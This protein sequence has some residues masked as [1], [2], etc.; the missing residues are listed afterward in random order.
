MAKLFSIPTQLIA[1]R[2]MCSRDPK[3]SGALLS[4]L[5]ASH[6]HGAE[7]TEALKAVLKYVRLKGSPP[8]FQVLAE[9]LKLSPET[10]DFLAEATTSP[11]TYDHAQQVIERLN[12]Y[13][14]TRI[15]FSLCKEGME[16]LQGKT[17]DPEEL[18]AMAQEKLSAMQLNKDVENQL[19]HIGRDGNSDEL[20]TKAIY[21]ADDDQWIPTCWKT[22]DSVNGGMPRGGLVLLGGST[23]AGKSHCVLQ[24]AKSQASLGYKVVVVPLEMS[25]QETAV[26]LL[27]NLGGMDSLKISLKRM[28]AEEQDFLWRRYRRFQKKVE[29]AGGRFTIFRPT[30]D[31]SIEETMAAVHSYNPDVV[32]I[33]YIGL[34]KGVDGGGEQAQWL[35]LGNAARYGKVYAGNHNKVVVLAA[36]VSEEGK[37]R[38]SQAIREHASLGFMFVATKESRE[39]GY[40]NFETIKSRNQQN[41]NFTLKVDYSTSTI[42]DL[43]AGEAMEPIEQAQTKVEGKGKGSKPAAKTTKPAQDNYMPDLD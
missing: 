9:D 11:K 16:K 42:K 6:F 18:I 43:E 35:Q 10:R 40:L 31:V 21:G 26:R 27:A 5:D 39:Q 25:E 28:A 15:F 7:C 8:S 32:Y 17:V 34:L 29:A 22:F 24:L 3:V 33:D 30:S 20:I 41:I 4:S 12:Q 2:G 36:Q 38:Y 1:L 14:H 19:F 13:R 23:G 37:I